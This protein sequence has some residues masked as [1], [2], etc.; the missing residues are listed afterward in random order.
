M[1]Q[2][3][4][5]S[6]VLDISHDEPV[7][8]GV[9]GQLARQHNQLLVSMRDA[10]AN[11]RR[12]SIKVAV[13][14]TRLRKLT[15]EAQESARQQKAAS[16]Q[17]AQS[18]GESASALDDITQRTAAVSRL[19]SENL[20][21]VRES[22]EAL[23]EVAQRIESASQ[24]IQA[25][26]QTVTGLSESAGQIGSI[27]ELVQGFSSQTNLLALNAAIEAARAGEHGRGFAVV[28]DEVRL[29][30]EKI[31]AA[32]G[33]VSGIIQDMDDRVRQTETDTGQLIDQ[34]EATRERIG[35]TATQ[36]NQMLQHIEEAN[37]DLIA[38]S[39]SVEQVSLTN[40]E[41]HDHSG[42]IQRL[43]QALAEEISQSDAYS[44][45]LREATEA[46]ISVLASYRIGQG[47]FER[48]LEE[49]QAMK[50]RLEEA[51]EAL[52]ADGVEV[53][54]RHY[55]P[56]PG[57][58]PAQFRTGYVDAFKAHLQDIIDQSKEAF[59]GI[60]YS[61]ILDVNGYLAVHHSPT[62]QPPTG[63]PETDLLHS[64]DQ[65]MYNANETEKRRAVNTRP[66]LLQTY[67]RDTGE[68]LNDLSLPLYVK[69]K[70]WG[71]LCTGFR[72]ELLLEDQADSA[73]P[74]TERTSV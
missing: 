26:Q 65:R 19:N 27:L 45:Q 59:P 17:I 63:N 25:F 30:A 34:T 18:S 1:Q 47:A 48:I 23:N 13:E 67:A 22:N 52:Y 11:L 28:A 62:S 74:E 3:Q 40:R 7:P 66:F 50:Q 53:F 32:T 44:A 70:H 4:G 35:A 54:D 31:A 58:N 57:T 43:G 2:A 68:I 15:G 29:L 39:A 73:Q 36:F 24:H 20:D 14:S 46:S 41:V 72:P 10:L 38:I 8:A 61:L 6:F 12:H 33:D 37:D 9:A 5:E 51:L 60:A 56:V 42:D 55:E 49:R 16:E 21:G 69:G 71:A 64:R